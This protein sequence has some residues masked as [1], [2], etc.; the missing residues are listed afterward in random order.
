MFPYG[1][2]PRKSIAFNILW[3][4]SPDKLY[5]S[6]MVLGKKKQVI[7]ALRKD[8]A[9]YVR[10]DSFNEGGVTGGSLIE[11]QAQSFEDKA[12]QK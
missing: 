2:T 9:V 6:Y 11:V 12:G 1:S 5:H 3:G 10:V 7:G 8:Q 4:Y